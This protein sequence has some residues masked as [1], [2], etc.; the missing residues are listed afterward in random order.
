M[1]KRRWD[2][3]TDGIS[4]KMFDRA[5]DQHIRRYVQLKEALVSVERHLA[6]LSATVETI[7]LF[8]GGHEKEEE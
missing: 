3:P 5:M 6:K 4:R 8:H 2:T 7:D 1:S